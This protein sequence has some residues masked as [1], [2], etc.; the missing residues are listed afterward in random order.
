MFF[1]LFLQFSDLKQTAG[2]RCNPIDVKKILSSVIQTMKKRAPDS[3]TQVLQKNPT[4]PMMWTISLS[5][6]YLTCP[7]QVCLFVLFIFLSQKTAEFF[8]E[9]QSLSQ[10]L[11]GYLTP[12]LT[13]TS[14]FLFGYLTSVLTKT[15]LPVR[16]LPINSADSVRLGA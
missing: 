8:G 5:L 10:F 1:E 16:K 13:K 12:M 3:E 15:S 14:Q 7:S 6:L 9:I 2:Q 4:L 11:L